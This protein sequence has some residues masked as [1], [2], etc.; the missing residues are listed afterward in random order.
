[1]PN[2]DGKW[3]P[4]SNDFPGVLTCGYRF[5]PGHGFAL[6]APCDGGLAIV[7]APCRASEST[8]ADIEKHGKVRAIVASNA[9]HNMG[10]AEWH[11]R[12][13]DARLFAPAQSIARVEKKSGV[14]GVKPIADAASLCGP[15]LELIDMPH[16]KSGEVL[17]RIT[18]GKNV[19]WYVTDVIL[20][21]SQLPG[22]FPFKYLFKW[23]NSAPGLRPNGVASKF[24]VK[25]K[26][27]LYRWLRSE[28]DKA[29]PAILVAA[30][31]DAIASGAADRL[32]EV[33][34]A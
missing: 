32:R 28:I 18:H 23:T 3:T 24:M 2:D 27:A 20:N 11:A 34:P 15:E 13:P 10:I 17:V 6:A 22:A 1:M 21:M 33:L 25:D 26:R 5:G 31:G 16:Y 29:P 4:V 7:S 30:H 8:F 19:L 9:F 12:F 14:S